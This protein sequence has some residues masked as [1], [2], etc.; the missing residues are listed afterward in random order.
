MDAYVIVTKDGFPLINSNNG[1]MAVFEDQ[2]SAAK[3][4]TKSGNK[5]YKIKKINIS[6]AVID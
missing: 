4:L 2:F 6:L 3:Y 5:T 1:V